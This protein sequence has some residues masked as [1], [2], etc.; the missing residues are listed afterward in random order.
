MAKRKNWDE[1]VNLTF[2]F[3]VTKT[4]G[5]TIHDLADHLEA[6][7][8]TAKNAIRKTRTTLG[9]GDINITAEPRAHNE[10]WV[11][12]LAGTYA[13]SRSWVTNRRKD[14]R[15]RIST[16]HAVHAAAAAHEDRRT[17]EGKQAALVT[18]VLGRLIEDLDELELEDA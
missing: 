5:F 10:P 1:I 2:D 11:Y 12:K 4:D 7:V 15:T 9:G 17:R 16:M 8:E 14:T 6:S 18:K 13:E 3:A